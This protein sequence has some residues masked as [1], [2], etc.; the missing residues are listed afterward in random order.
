MVLEVWK[1]LNNFCREFVRIVVE[2]SIYKD[3]LSHLWDLLVKCQVNH[4]LFNEKV[5]LAFKF[6][7][8]LDQVNINQLKFFFFLY[9]KKVLVKVDFIAGRGNRRTEILGLKFCI[10]FIESKYKRVKNGPVF[11]FVVEGWQLLNNFKSLADFFLLKPEG[12]NASK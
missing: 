12:L 10:V 7:A 2:K 1:S 3:N 8:L 4:I 6:L 9:S 11:L 5:K